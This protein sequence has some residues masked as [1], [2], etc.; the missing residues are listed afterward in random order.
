M[1]QLLMSS[2]GEGV[3]VVNKQAECTFVNAVLLSL[4][5]Y[6]Q[7]QLVD[8]NICHLFVRPAGVLVEDGYEG[9]PIVATIQDRQTRSFEARLLLANGQYLPVHL[10]ISAIIEFGEVNGAEVI[11]QDI[12]KQKETEQRLFRLA[13]FDDMT[14]FANR[15]YFT[16]QLQKNRIQ[17]LRFQQPMS[18][19]MLDLDHFKRINDTYGHAAGDAA[20]VAFASLVQAE[21]QDDDW[22][23]RMGGEEFAILKMDTLSNVMQWAQNLRQVIAQHEVCHDVNCFK[24]TVS[25]GVAPLSAKDS[26]ID[27]WLA[28]ADRYLYQA[29]HLGRNRVEG[30]E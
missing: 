26:S 23:G 30:G 29:K 6:T 24:F 18:L 8:H 7:P 15:R 5:G 1:L 11:V 13:N 17:G 9:G 10:T 22:A 3:L 27:Q 2:L 14:G 21:L 20:L 4:T 28:H 19:L 16:E 25:M 12:S